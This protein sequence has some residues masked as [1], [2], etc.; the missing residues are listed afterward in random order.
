MQVFEIGSQ[1]AFVAFVDS[2][3]YVF[4]VQDTESTR[5]R[6]QLPFLGPQADATNLCRN[7]FPR[8]AGP[9]FRLAFA[10]RR[11]LFLIVLSLPR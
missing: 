2:A 1:G 10:T 9:V 4:H 8:A 6:E 3:R 11:F 7:S 5:L